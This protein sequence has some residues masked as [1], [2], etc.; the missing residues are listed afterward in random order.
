MRIIINP[1]DS[2]GDRVPS[3]VLGAA[4]VGVNN[5]IVSLG[6]MA[7]A[8]TSVEATFTH[9]NGFD[10]NIVFQD[11]LGNKL[12]YATDYRFI[13][14]R[15]LRPKAIDITALFSATH[16]PA[17]YIRKHLEDSFAKL[18]QARTELEDQLGTKK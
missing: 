18:D 13:Q 9:E 14:G 8:V 2:N 3:S 6:A 11:A 16:G 1:I 17:S 7:S 5:G 4:V 12:F 10:M 15:R